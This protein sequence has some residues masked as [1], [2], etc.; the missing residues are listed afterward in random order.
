[1]KKMIAS[2]CFLSLAANLAA[3]DLPATSAAALRG[4]AVTGLPSVRMAAVPAAES[5]Y[6]GWSDLRDG[7]F[8]AE[9]PADL[10]SLLGVYTGHLHPLYER[11][12]YTVD[13]TMTIYRDDT[14][15]E[16]KAVFPMPP[17]DE[18]E[19]ITL[20]LTKYGAEFS[21]AWGGRARLVIRRDGGGLRIFSNLY[22]DETYG[23]CAEA[24]KK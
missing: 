17:N 22:S 10:Y 3:F 2:A 5:V 11:E 15:G 16:I 19:T 9:A 18:P 8:R 12:D 13:F 1:M 23:V 14:T 20:K 24:A 6:P 21:D 4:P 7:F